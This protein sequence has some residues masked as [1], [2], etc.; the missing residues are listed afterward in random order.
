MLLLRYWSGR[1]AQSV[2]VLW[3]AFTVSFLVLYGLPGDPVTLMLS[4]GGSSGT[5]DPVAVASLNHEFGF[6]RPLILQYF[7]R[8]GAFVTGNFGISIDQNQDVLT[9]VSRGAWSTLQIALLGFAVAIALGLGIAVLASSTRMRWLR[10]LLQSLPPLAL[11]LPTFWLGLVLIQVFAFQLH[12]FPSFGDKT[13]NTLVLPV[14]TLAIPAS[15][16]VAQ[17]LTK[18]FL[19]VWRQPFVQVAQA[20]GFGRRQLLS[21]H[22]LRNAVIPA[23]T[24]AG[25]TFGQLL[26]GAVITETVFSRPG[27]G[28]MTQRAVQSQDLPVVQFMVVLAAVVFVT[29]NLVVDALYPIIDPRI[30]RRGLVTA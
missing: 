28:S 14:L 6:D 24:M 4:Q 7:D 22:V 3:A 12:L 26:A 23:L 25:I 17:V 8:L 21:K 10:Q 16:G 18:S 29:I 13:A 1:A 27:L 5:L 11:S 30:R 2:F 15:A 19:G 9:I 20:K